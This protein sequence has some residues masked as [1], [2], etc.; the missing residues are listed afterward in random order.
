MENLFAAAAELTDA[1]HR[2]INLRE[3]SNLRKRPGSVTGTAPWYHLERVLVNVI[4][5]H[6]RNGGMAKW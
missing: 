5:K 1:G 3:T 4:V 2:P 6:S